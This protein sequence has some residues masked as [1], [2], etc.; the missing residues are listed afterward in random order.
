MVIFLFSV[1]EST[2]AQNISSSQPII[3]PQSPAT[4][5]T[6]LDGQSSTIKSA[7]S[8]TL[9]DGVTFKK[10]ADVLVEIGSVDPVEVESNLNWTWSRTYNANGTVVA[11]NKAYFDLT[12]R[13]TQQQYRNIS[14]SQILA[15]Q[16][17]YDAASRPVLSTLPAPINSSTFVFKDKFVLNASNLSYNYKNFDRYANGSNILDKTHS[18]DVIS[19]KS[20]PGTL[21]W[22]YSSN[23]TLEPMQASTDYPYSRQLFTFDGSEIPIKS[24]FPGDEYRVGKNHEMA[25]YTAPVI[26]ELS[27]YLQV[28]N[29]FFPTNEVGSAPLSLL[30]KATIT[31]TKDGNDT[32]AI[33]IGN[34]DGQ[35]LLSA[36]IGTEHTVNNT[37]QIKNGAAT[38]LP[39]DTGFHYFNL[40]VATT[41]NISGG[42]WQLYK[43][44]EGGQL[45]AFTSGQ[46]LAKGYY[47]LQATSTT[48]VN[49]TYSYGIG[50]ISYNFY[51]QLG[52]LVATV[53]PEGVKKLLGA[54]INNFSNKT[55][56]PF[57]TLYE[58]DMQG[59]LVSVKEPDAAG[60]TEFVYRRDGNIRFSQNAQQRVA[61]K[62]SYTNYDPLGRPIES[63]EYS[64]VGTSGIIF[65]SSA[66]KNLIENVSGNGGL[67]NGIKYDVVKTSYD[68]MDISHALPGYGQNAYMLRGAVTFT[69]RYS[70]IDNAP[71]STNLVSRTWYNYDG[72]G[73]VIWVITYLHGLGYQ[74]TD[75]TYDELN[76]ITKII[77]QKNNA[78]ECFVHYYD[79]D[80]DNRLSAV[81]TNT[82]DNTASRLLQAK[83]YY[84][85]HGPLKRVEL[86]NNLQ[87]IDYTYT[88]DGKLK[89]INHANQAAD[90]GKDGISNAFAPDVFG[91]NVEYHPN[92]YVRSGSNIASIQNASYPANYNGNINGISWFSKKPASVT[93][94]DAVVMNAYKYDAR[95]QL[96]NNGWGTP[97]FSTNTYAETA[98]LNKEFDLSYD[99]NGNI[100]TLKRNNSTG[101]AA[102]NFTYS[103]GANTNKLASVNGYATYGYNAIGQLTSEVKTDRSFYLDYDVNGKVTKIYGDAAKTQ[104]KFSFVYNEVGQRIKKQD[105]SNN[106]ITWY[107]YD[108]S[109]QL[110]AIYDNLDGGVTKLKEQ[111]VYAGSKVGT[112]F[113]QANNYQY[114]LSDHLG[115]VRAV[116]NR[117]KLSSGNADVVFYADY[118]PFGTV[119]RSGGTGWRYGYQGEYAEKDGETGWNNFELRNYDAAI[120]RWLST[121]PYGQYASPYV[122]MG[123]NPVSFIDPDGGKDGVFTWLSGLFGG[124]ERIKSEPRQISWKN[125]NGDSQVI[126]LDEAIVNSYYG[127]SI[128]AFRPDVWDQ[129]AD[130]KDFISKFS[131][132]MIDPFVVYSTSFFGNPRHIGGEGANRNELTSAGIDV[133]TSFMPAEKI[134]Q[135]EVKAFKLLNASEFNTLMKGSGLTAATSGG[136]V[137]RS[138]NYNVKEVHMLKSGYKVMDKV[139]SGVKYTKDSYGILKDQED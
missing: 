101:T 65:N 69:E 21:G 86:A 12:G 34:T 123:N 131:Y 25:V 127:G 44:S 72:M 56:I 54:G 112:F 68:I 32:E 59:R 3:L 66:M 89:A 18:P 28:R 24:G 137:I 133:I 5:F 1:E 22:Y 30:K 57:I 134:L 42:S 76:N 114:P 73:R 97:N 38:I 88:A 46:S 106:A 70:V 61:N 71:S 52:Q 85:L 122:G 130:G 108:G 98:N 26:N 19:G 48:A 113:K 60:K 128:R 49:L 8:V 6:V 103:Y 91:M 55:Q 15:T 95:N 64:P 84:Y 136:M 78:A 120:G 94:L 124:G 2:F 109:G 132:K 105:H 67:N 51:N 27:H 121:D 45:V 11:E 39:S 125:Y 41:V 36:L 96:S 43:M 4:S 87:G 102:A 31:I 93:G 74:T 63:G 40:P 107:V 23:N 117:N 53:A 104:L 110:A 90:P 83:Y 135:S 77:Y 92:D 47:R 119:L 58:Y 62:F 35:I 37:V 81:Y 13:P 126:L 10:Y 99:G 118:Y 79:Y 7:V 20:T 139:I 129:W 100:L 17:I 33:S 111:A 14:S 115:N 16:T 138:Y 29:K 75:Y 82:V 116:I 50:V 80:A 9:N